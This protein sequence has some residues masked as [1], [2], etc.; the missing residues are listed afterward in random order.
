MCIVQQR[1]VEKGL[2]VASF[3]AAVAFAFTALL[4]SQEHEVTANNL[5]VVAQFL[6]LSAS[7]IGIDYKLGSPA[8]KQ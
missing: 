3:V 1:R 2:S 8:L 4:V 6:T 5:L 7:I